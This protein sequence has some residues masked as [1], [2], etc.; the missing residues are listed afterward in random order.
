MVCR[1]GAPPLRP[2]YVHAALL[3]RINV[4]KCSKR[5]RTT[6]HS[7]FYHFLP[8]KDDTIENHLKKHMVMGEYFNPYVNLDN[9]LL[10]FKV[11]P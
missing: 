7:S 2:M 1:R 4:C 5:L 11:N 6:G 10:D 3:Q 8:L 9:Y